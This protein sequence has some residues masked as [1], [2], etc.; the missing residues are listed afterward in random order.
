[1][2]LEDKLAMAHKMSS[3]ESLAISTQQVMEQVKAL[4]DKWIEL[5]TL[6]GEVVAKVAYAPFAHWTVER[7]LRRDRKDYLPEWKTISVSGIKMINDDPV[8]TDWMLSGGLN[9]EDWYGN[10]ELTSAAY[11]TKAKLSEELFS[12]P[13]LTLSAGKGYAFGPVVL[14]ENASQKVEKD[15]IVVLKNAS[16]EFQSQM[17]QATK[18]GKGAVI[19]ETGS[20]VAHLA[21]VGRESGVII[22]KVKDAFEKFMDGDVVSLNLDKNSVHIFGHDLDYASRIENQKEILKTKK[23]PKTT[24]IKP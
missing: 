4:G 2:P 12:I 13:L 16:P 5:K 7:F 9:L 11:H 3:E 24:K 14:V 21:K 22:V 20:A 10:E 6:E 8:H 1:M 15:S 19:V 18:G 23:K 17:I